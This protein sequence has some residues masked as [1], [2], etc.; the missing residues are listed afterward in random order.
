VGMSTSFS[1]TAPSTMDIP[2]S[3]GASTVRIRS[4]RNRHPGACPV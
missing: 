2:D 3:L 4:G 1:A